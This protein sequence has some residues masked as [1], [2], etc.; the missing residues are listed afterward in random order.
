VG[1]GSAEEGGEDLVVLGEV[2]ATAGVGGEEAGSWVVSGLDSRRGVS[3]QS[4][5]QGQVSSGPEIQYLGL[6][7]NKKDSQKLQ[8]VEPGREY[9]WGFGFFQGLGRSLKRFCGKE[10]QA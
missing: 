9:T 4:Q 3:S 7:E 6:P 5:K 8:K 2:G 10:L 1:E